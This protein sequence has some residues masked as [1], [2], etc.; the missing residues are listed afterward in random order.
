[1]SDQKPR[2]ET[3]TR[4]T[5]RAVLAAIALA[6]APAPAGVHFVEDSIS[7]DLGDTAGVGG[8]HAWCELLGVNYDRD[9]RHQRYDEGGARGQLWNATAEG[10]WG[11]TYIHLSNMDTGPDDAALPAETVTAL[12]ELVAERETGGADQ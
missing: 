6:P 10:V 4:L 3:E 1:M 2:T 7:I 8:F 12:S 11:W 9:V 5:R